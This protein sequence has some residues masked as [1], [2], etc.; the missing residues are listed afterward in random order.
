MGSFANLSK[1]VGSVSIPQLMQEEIRDNSELIVDMPKS[2]LEQTGTYADGTQI[3]TYNAIGD[4]V[5]SPATYFYKAE[6]G[7]PSDRVTLKDTGAFYASFDTQADNDGFY[8]TGNSDKPDGQIEDNVD[9]DGVLDL[10]DKEKTE[11]V[12]NLRPQLAKDV[13]STIL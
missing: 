6:K 3:R 1:R 8:I 4:G 9:M 7:Q 13:K 11:L 2:R 5:Y 12:V 10:S